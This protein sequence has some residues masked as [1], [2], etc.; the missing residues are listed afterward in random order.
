M[1]LAQLH[2]KVAKLFMDSACENTGE[3]ICTMRKDNRGACITRHT[4]MNEHERMCLN[5]NLF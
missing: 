3:K 4:S 2:R 5:A 1:L